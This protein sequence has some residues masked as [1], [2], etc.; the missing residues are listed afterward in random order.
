VKFKLS[1]DPEFVDK[2]RDIVGPFVDPPAHAV[3]P[4]VCST[5]RAKGPPGAQPG[6]PMN[7]GRAVTMT[8]DYKRH[9]TTSL[10]G[11]SALALPHIIG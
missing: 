9:G 10:F 3:V 7:K 4:L 1:K 8:H 5:N 11:V 2:L 6:L